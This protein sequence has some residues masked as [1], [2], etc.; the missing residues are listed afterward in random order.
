MIQDTKTLDELKAIEPQIPDTHLDL[1]TVKRDELTE[2]SKA[3][4]NGKV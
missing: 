3:K 2:Q 1:L 4:K